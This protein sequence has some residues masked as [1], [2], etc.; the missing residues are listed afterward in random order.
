MVIITIIIGV[1]VLAILIIHTFLTGN[2]I[3]KQTN[4]LSE[5]IHTYYTKSELSEEEIE[6]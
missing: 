1:F 2:T 6:E 4:E 3:E 5:G